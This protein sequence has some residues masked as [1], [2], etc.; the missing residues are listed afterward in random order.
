MWRLQFLHGQIRDPL[1]IVFW[2]L[3]LCW[4]WRGLRLLQHSRILLVVSKKQSSNVLC[5]L[6]CDDSCGPG[7]MAENHVPRVAPAT[8]LDLCVRTSCGTHL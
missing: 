5:N 3:L 6:R 8:L 7:A 1:R 4:C 2:R